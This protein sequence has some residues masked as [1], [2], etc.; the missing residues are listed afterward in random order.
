MSSNFFAYL[1]KSE[2]LICLEQGDSILR[3]LKRIKNEIM[4]EV[5]CFKFPYQGSHYILLVARFIE[6]MVSVL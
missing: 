1:N 2:S 5:A 4:F 3:V 6:Q